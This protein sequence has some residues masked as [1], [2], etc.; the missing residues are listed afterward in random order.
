MRGARKVYTS[1]PTEVKKLDTGRPGVARFLFQ[2]PLAKI[3]AGQYT[4]QVNIFDT[5]GKKFATPRNAIYVLPDEAAAAA[6]AAAP[7]AAPNQ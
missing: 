3:P 6:P 5:T 7:P 1:A 2:I 4:T